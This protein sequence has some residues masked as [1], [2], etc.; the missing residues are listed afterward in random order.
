MKRLVL[1][2]SV[3]VLSFAA[4]MTGGNMLVGTSTWPAAVLVPDPAWTGNGQT[5]ADQYCN[6]VNHQSQN[7]QI[8]FECFSVPDPTTGYWNSVVRL[9]PKIGNGYGYGHE[10]GVEGTYDFATGTERVNRFY[11]WDFT[12]TPGA[13]NG[14][15]IL[16]HDQVNPFLLVLGGEKAMSLYATGDVQAV[17][18]VQANDYYSSTWKRGLTVTS[19]KGG[20]TC[21]GNF[22][23]GLCVEK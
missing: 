23:N 2:I 5:K 11:V 8:A 10:I 6:A 20:V 7:N 14:H 12:P 19:T 9:R 21:P 3:A 17:G 1:I 22:V 4:V 13:P 15:T 16:E 18:R